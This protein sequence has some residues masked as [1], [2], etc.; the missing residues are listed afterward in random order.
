MFTRLIEFT[1]N[2]KEFDEEPFNPGD[3]IELSFDT[4]K[5]SMSLEYK[6]YVQKSELVDDDCVKVSMNIVADIPKIRRHPQE[7]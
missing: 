3:K 5:G 7:A 6:F 2:K 4:P 1:M